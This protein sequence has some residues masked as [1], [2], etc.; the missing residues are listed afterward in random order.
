MCKQVV[1]VRANSSQAS[2]ILDT[3]IIT[4]Y[5]PL[6]VIR[7]INQPIAEY[8]AAKML[9]TSP[10]KYK[11]IYSAKSVDGGDILYRIMLFDVKITLEVLSKISEDRYKRF[12][13]SKCEESKRLIDIYIKV[14]TEI[15]KEHRK[16]KKV[17]TEY[18]YNKMMEL[19]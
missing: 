19:L 2:H 17:T 12:N 5:F 11:M 7:R 13:K 1:K 14:V 15:S 6:R 10:K 8:L 18:I 16:Y 3:S 9:T 4:K